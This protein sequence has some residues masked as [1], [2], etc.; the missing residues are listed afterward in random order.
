VEAFR[1]LAQGLGVV[2]AQSGAPE[3]V[4]VG[5]TGELSRVSEIVRRVRDG[6]PWLVVIEGESGIGKSALARRATAVAEP[7]ALLLATADGA[8][9]D[10]EYGVAQQLLQRVDSQLPMGPALLAGGP[11]PGASPFA[12]GAD[13]LAVIGRMLAKGPVVIAVDDVQWADRPSIQALTFVLRRLSVE[14][15]LAVVVLR[16][17]REA[18]DD[19]TSRLLVSVDRRLNLRLGGLEVEDI[20]PLANAMGLRPVPTETAKRLHEH[21]GGHALYLRTLLSEQSVVAG[22]RWGRIPVT[23]SLAVAVGDQLAQLSR[24]SRA[25]LEILAVVDRPLPLGRLGEVA[26]VPS[27]SAAIEPALAAG[28][29]D[30]QPHVPSCPVRLRHALQRDAIYALLTPTKRRMLH[31]RA[32]SVVDATAAWAHRVAALDGPDDKLAEHLAQSAATEAAAGQFPLAA[33]H[34]LWAG[35]ISSSRD[36]YEERLLAAATYLML[37]DEARGLRLREAVEACRPSPLRNCVLASMALDTGRL[38]E[39]E[40]LL[41]EATEAVGADGDS[42]PL[43][44][45]IANRLAGVYC[46]LGR[47]AEAMAAGRRAVDTGALDRAAASQTRT[48]I[49]IGASQTEGPRAALAELD[50]LDA[51]PDRIGP[52]D[53]DALSFRGVFHLL[54]GHLDLAVRDLGVSVRLVREGA[55]FTLGLRAYLYLA[56]AQYLSGAWDGVLLTAEQALSEA[57]VHSRRYELPLLHLAAAC[58]P[59][60]RG[61]AEEAEQ[62]AALAE[63]AAADLP[64][65]QERLYAGMARALTCQAAGDYPGMVAALTP[66]H[67]NPALDGRARLYGVLW[68]PLLVEGFL[69][70][71]RAADAEVEF[72]QLAAQ[73]KDVVFLRPALAWL[74][75]W[76]E[77]GRG[78]TATAR[79]VY[80]RASPGAAADCPLYAAHLFLSYG[81]LLRRMGERAAAVERLSQAKQIFAGVGATPFLRQVERELAE[82]GQRRRAPDPPGGLQMTSREAEVAQLVALGLTDGEVAAKLFVT[83]KAISY[84]LSNIYAKHGLSG[85]RQ[86]RQLLTEMGSGQATTSRMG[87]KDPLGQRPSSR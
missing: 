60:G 28:L 11:A 38:G 13:M 54:S 66:W 62:H 81:R 53:L 2:V 5:R 82:C 42:L 63:A 8:E 48:L 65:G 25:V 43:A 78:S 10:L 50:H 75:G 61:A 67:D 34:L 18:L 15:L 7:C 85:R 9:A 24:D 51:D 47:G 26:G 74:E 77:E 23:P 56:L 12:V 49:A 46:L 58:V 30:W 16:G 41:L 64:Y 3:D 71:G 17:D 59:A 45:L 87:S 40:V 79:E 52:V 4:F 76:L 84:H 22:T 35:D 86:L 21:T 14:P 6:E 33:T 20:P 69:G 31:A 32:V 27:P 72:E 70:S 83:P 37:A 57:A 29:A 55:T 44:A 36:G 39:A 1:Y 80:E 73:S 19:A 68:R